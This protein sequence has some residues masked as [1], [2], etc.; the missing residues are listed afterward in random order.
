MI[1]LVICDN[2]KYIQEY[3]PKHQIII[4]C[5]L[6]LLTHVFFGLNNNVET[7]I[8]FT[9]TECTNPINVKTVLGS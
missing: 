6:M 4:I 3:T 8:S 2:I 1:Y 7:L 5:I 9:G